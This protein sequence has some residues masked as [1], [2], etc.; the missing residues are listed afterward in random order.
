M[1]IRQRREFFHPSILNAYRNQLPR[2]IPSIGSLRH[3]AIPEHAPTPA[4][5]YNSLAV[6]FNQSPV[7]PYTR[8]RIRRTADTRPAVFHLDAMLHRVLDLSPVIHYSAA[9]AESQLSKISS[10]SLRTGRPAL[11]KS[12]D[13]I[14]SYVSALYIR[15][16]WMETSP[17]DVAGAV[18]LNFA[19]TQDLPLLIT[20]GTIPYSFQLI[21]ASYLRPPSSPAKRAETAEYEY[22]NQFILPRLIQRVWFSGYNILY[23]G[24]Y[25]GRPEVR[26]PAPSFLAF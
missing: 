10:A 6:S 20:L 5:M 17:P 3:A 26:F 18:V 15:Y 22:K 4:S 8:H 21:L 16:I 1:S 12:G 2:I 23:S 25:I 9:P 11:A 13:A 7:N 24:A 19:A 14:P